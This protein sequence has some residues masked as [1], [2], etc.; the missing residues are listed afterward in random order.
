MEKWTNYMEIEISWV[1]RAY[2]SLAKTLCSILKIVD[3]KINF[4]IFFTE[5]LE[6]DKIIKLLGWLYLDVVSIDLASSIT[7]GWFNLNQ[8]KIIAGGGGICYLWTNLEKVRQGGAI[9]VLIRKKSR[10]AL[11][12]N[13][14]GCSNFLYIKN[15][16]SNSE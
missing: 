6:I 3:C 10:I 13:T 2:I 16:F 1:I 11:S 4:L 14:G 5:K 12:K 8:C 9:R 7:K 15:I